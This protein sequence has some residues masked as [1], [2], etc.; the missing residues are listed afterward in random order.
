MTVDELRRMPYCEVGDCYIVSTGHG[1]SGPFTFGGVCLADLMAAAAPAYPAWQHVD[2]VSADGFG[3]RLTQLDLHAAAADRPILLA[4]T[5][6]GS[7]L[8]RARGLVR[9]IVPA[10][11]DD[12][13]Q[14]VKWVSRI[15]V[16]A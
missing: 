14:Q 15:D 2:V 11:V 10:E 7:P 12:A 1:T 3:V 13:L 6:D 16:K 4:Y 9:L 5:L 8:P